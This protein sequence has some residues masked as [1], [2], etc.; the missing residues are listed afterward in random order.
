MK[1]FPKRMV[2]L[3]GFIGKEENLDILDYVRALRNSEIFRQTILP[4]ELAEIFLDDTDVMMDQV[5]WLADHCEADEYRLIDLATPMHVLTADDM[6][7]YKTARMN[8]AEPTDL[9]YQLIVGFDCEDAYERF[10]EKSW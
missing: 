9:V 1:N 8:G 3:Y 10:T 4:R 7:A 5:E 2:R 6:E